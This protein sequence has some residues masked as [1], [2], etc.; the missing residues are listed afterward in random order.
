MI[1]EGLILSNIAVDYENV[2][3]G[4]HIL[5]SPNTFGFF[6]YLDITNIASSIFALYGQS[7]SLKISNITNIDD[8]SYE[9]IDAVSPI[10]PT[11]IDTMM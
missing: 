11:V 7:Y 8:P 9:T 3:V 5:E 6:S 2:P 4:W 1:V 10:Y